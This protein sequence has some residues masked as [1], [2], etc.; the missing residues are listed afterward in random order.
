MAGAAGGGKGQPAGL[1]AHAP[2]AAAASQHGAEI[3]L[4]GDR[5]TQ[6]S[7]DKGFQLY[8]AGVGNLPHFF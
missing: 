7:V 1:G 4:A 5:H 3:A 2:V 6:R 8:R